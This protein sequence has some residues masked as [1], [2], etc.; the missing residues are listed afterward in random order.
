MILLALRVGSSQ[1]RRLLPR[2]LAWLFIATAVFTLQI[3]SGAYSADL[4]AHPD[5]PA[6]MVSALLVHDYLAAGAPRS[7]FEYAKCYYLHY[8]KVAIGH[9]PPIFHALAGL[10]MFVAGRRVAAVLIL[11]ALAA[12]ALSIGIF[13]L[14]RHGCGAIA[15]L[16]IALAFATARTVQFATSTIL[17]DLVLGGFVFAAAAFWGS[18]IDTGKR[19]YL[20]AFA[21][22]AV[23][24]IGTHGRGVVV[25]LVPVIAAWTARPLR[26]T[27]ARVLTTALVVTV[28][29][30]LPI[31]AK[32]SLPISPASV[33]VNFL[34]F[35]Y[36]L[37]VSFLWIVPALGLCGL[38]ACFRDHRP[39]RW[40]AMAALV[41]ANWIFFSVVNTPFDQRYLLTVAPAMA[42]L[43]ARGW[44]LIASLNRYASPALP[45]ALCVVIGANLIPPYRQPDAG[46][47]SVIAN[48][49]RVDRLT[50]VDGNAASEGSAVASMLLHDRPFEH[51]V[52]RATKA[53]ASATWAG[54]DY[55]LLC[56][57]PEEVRKVLDREG[58]DTVISQDPPWFPHSVLLRRALAE[59]PLWREVPNRHGGIRVF[60]R[61]TPSKSAGF[62]LRI[63]NPGGFRAVFECNE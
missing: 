26:F 33:V 38:V 17:P 60:Q 43:A 52:V 4:S 10:W 8:P 36:R 32:Q 6:H 3:D 58:I 24:A 21:V 18:Y 30:G 50:L 46:Y 49:P 1:A 20:A 45:L 7:A 35:P 25:L 56:T 22:L 13:E 2:L 44:S 53:L 5:E 23:L 57:T 55:R 14:G 31:A 9:W 27:P 37:G 48:L 42:V 41:A 29:L 19:F 15:A 16:L 34:Q 11:L 54:N 51:V 12:I 61:I 40:T 28:V 62:H 47:A 39:S 59:T 63:D